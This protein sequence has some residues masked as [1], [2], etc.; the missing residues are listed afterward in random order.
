MFHPRLTPPI[1]GKKKLTLLFPIAM[2][3]AIRSYF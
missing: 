1:S 3:P 2:I